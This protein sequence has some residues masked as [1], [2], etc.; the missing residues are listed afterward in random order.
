MTHN[1]LPSQLNQTKCGFRYTPTSVC[2]REI[3]DHTD[4]ATCESCGNSGTCD[5]YC[6]DTRILLCQ[7]CLEKERTS[8]IER[9]GIKIATLDSAKT[10]IEESKRLDY[11]I[12]DW[13]Q[14]FNARPVSIAELR[15]K[16]E[17][18]ESVENKH[19]T[20]AKVLDDRFK[21]LSSVLGLVNQK[22]KELSKQHQEIQLYYNELSK[23]LKED[24]KKEISLKDV[25]YKPIEIT[26]KQKAPSIKKYDA[27]RIKLASAESGISAALIQMTCV[28]R[29]V[30][31]LEA[32][33]IL[34]SQGM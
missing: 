28:A 33:R 6:G 9:G 19:F 12:H 11:S 7:D 10:L 24:E 14:V 29:N 13:T 3:H 2:G 17:H 1:F 21:H 22:Q 27:Q 34:K 30:E 15:F 4:K 31:P 8:A 20:L 5:F 18:D 25:N 16:I 32:V 26:K 23:K